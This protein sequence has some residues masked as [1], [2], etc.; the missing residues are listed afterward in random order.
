VFLM[1]SPTLSLCN[2]QGCVND[3]REIK[4]FF[5]DKLHVE[6]PRVLTS[7]VLSSSASHPEEPPNRWPT[8]SNIKREF[9]TVFE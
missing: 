7:S 8:F 6:E 2:L 5:C 1:Q 3:I 9:D 4:N